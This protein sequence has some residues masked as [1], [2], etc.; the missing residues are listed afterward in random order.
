MPALLERPKLSNAMARALHRHIMMERERK[1]QEEEEVDKMMEQKMREEQE[2]RRKKELEERMSLEETKE[3]IQKLQQKLTALQEEKHQLFLQLKK[4]LHEEEKRR[5]KEQNDMSTLT[6]AAYQQ[7]MAVHTGT[8][9]INMQ[10]SPGGHN[11]PTT[12]MADRAKQ[13]FGSQVMASRHYPGQPGF[14]PGTPEHGQYTSSQSSHSPYAVSQ[15]PHG[16]GPGQAVPVSYAGGQPIRGPSAFQAMQYLSHQ[17]QAY[18]VHG[19]FPTAQTGFIPPSAGIPLQ[20]Q[21]E[22]ANQQSGFTDSSP[23]RPMHPQAIHATQTLLPAPQLTVQMQPTKA[24]LA[25]TR[26]AS[27]GSFTHGTPPQQAHTSGFQAAVQ[28]SPR[29]SF[30]PHGQTQR[31]YHK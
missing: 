12:L 1:R 24:A 10:G 22:H 13:M 7:S 17:P 25:Y 20:K 29:H 14:A 19:H 21:L 15:S 18:S 11:R 16:F 4:V 8:H 28:Q 5:R 26:P 30:A 2:R 23:L 27:P 9:L 31:F 3:Q 6:S